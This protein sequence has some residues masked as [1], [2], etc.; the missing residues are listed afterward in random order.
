MLDSSARTQ[1]APSETAR[2]Q[3]WMAVLAKA[4]PAL[5]EAHWQN[6][7]TRPGYLL[8]RPP[9]TGLVMV[10]GRISGS[11]APFNLGEMTM[12]RC[13]IRLED[14]PVGFG[15][16]AG[17]SRRHAELAALFDGMLQ[18]PRWDDALQD[19]LIAGLVQARAARRAADRARIAATRVD[20][21]TLA[22]GE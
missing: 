6:L 20:F 15:H 8:L 5:L 10:R 18:D 21:F 3:G 4:D 1:S 9:E 13:A 19:T 2:R 12:T 14:G 16:V 22:R 17:R 11:G 7:A